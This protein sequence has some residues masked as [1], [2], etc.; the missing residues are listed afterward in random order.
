MFECVWGVILECVL[1]LIPERTQERT[2][3]KAR[4]NT[5]IVIAFM[6]YDI[7]FFPVWPFVSKAS[8]CL[9]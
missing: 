1:D 2:L 8:F 3:A 9:I 6:C 7:F 5:E 4:G